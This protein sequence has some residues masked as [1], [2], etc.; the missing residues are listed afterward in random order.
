MQQT[1]E[2]G[3]QWWQDAVIYELYVDKFA[4]TFKELA[5]RLDYLAD[6]GVTCVHILPHYPSPMV[7]DGY[8][9]SD[10]YNVR[11]ELGTLEDF[12][13]FVDAA[14][15]HDIRVLV[16]FVL[17][18]VSSLHPWFRE[19]RA[20]V[21]SDKRNFFIWNETGHGL[22]N[23]INA[24]PDVKPNDWIWNE[25]THDFYFAT[26]YPEQPDLNWYE[27]RV[28]EEM[29]AILDFWIDLGV[30]AFRLDAVPFLMEK[31]GTPSVSLPET[32]DV[33]KRLRAHVVSKNPDV[34][35]LAEVHRPIDETVRYFGNG[36]ECNLVYGFP[37][38]EAMYLFLAT[39]DRSLLDQVAPLHTTLPPGCAW[40][41]F[42]SNHDNI[43]L[44]LVPAEKREAVLDFL[45]P[46]RKHFFGSGTSVRLGTLFRNDRQ[47]TLSAFDVL[48]SF[49]G[50]PVIYYGD[51]IGM[52]NEPL[53]EGELDKR[54]IMRGAFDWAKAKR[55]RDDPSSLYSQLRERI[56]ARKM[57]V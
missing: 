42:L 26:F 19:A 9:I 51:E 3:H 29:A 48:F 27:P 18:H 23:A 40:A 21:D 56:R 35:L 28:F 31:E 7:D 8:D 55:D 54:R 24:F 34:A 36:D 47:R 44:E 45:D 16:D 57:G 11:G 6:L 43:E 20:S 30:D 53:A 38:M 17:N 37:L 5:Q 52:Q 10:Y 33:L 39:G 1:N 50:S 46:E 4:G 49:S 13:A 12:K 15:R 22:E 25:E 2:P 14:H 32:H 41:T